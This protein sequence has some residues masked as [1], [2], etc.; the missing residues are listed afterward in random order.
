LPVKI[1]NSLPARSVLG[2]EHIF[3]MTERRAL[4]QDIRPL[5]IALVNLMPTKITTETQILRCLANTP[6]Q[7]EVDL[8]QTVSHK[9]KNTPEDHLLRF[10]ETFDEIKNRVYD[11]C[12]ITGAP[13]ELMDYEDVDYWPELCRIFEWTK[14][15][16]HS[17]FHICW[18]AQA[19]LYYHYGI[20]KYILP[21]KVFGVFPHYALTKKSRLF[22]GF[23]DVYWVPHSRQ[24][25]VRVEDIEKVPQLRIMSM[26]PEVGVHIVSDQEGRQ[27]FVMGHS[28]YDTETLGTEY[29][30]DLEK[31]EPI[32]MPKHYYPGNDISR[33]PVNKW[34]ATGQLLYTNWLNYFVY[35]T[36]PF[37]LRSI[38][39]SS[40]DCAML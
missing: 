31:G 30:R 32:A 33:E 16:V 39:G 34:R 27:Y 3:V 22:R 35:Q 20:P 11:G 10:Y 37:D 12:I 1:P 4:H 18:A 17:T 7:I 29:R 15:H 38:S 25:E 9:S 36:T 13:V 23:D 26:S 6:L 19:G 40:L 21:R 14:T 5:R 24:T 28:E 8:V 2:K